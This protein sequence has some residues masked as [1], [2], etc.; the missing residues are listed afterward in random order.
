MAVTVSSDLSVTVS[1]DQNVEKL[2]DKREALK[3]SLKK[4]ESKAVGVS[5]VMLGFLIISYSVP[6]LS[7]DFTEVLMFGVPW[8]SG[9]IFVIAGAFTLVMEKCNTIEMVFASLVVTVLATVISVIALI[10]YIIDMMNNPETKCKLDSTQTCD[11]RH[12]ATMFNLGIK[13]ILVCLYTV[14]TSISSAF[15]IILYKERER[16]NNYSLV[17]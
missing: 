15:S 2:I 9:L 13:S 10:I 4:G 8:W 6:L 14:A 17:L 5:Q 3:E 7:A 16:F 11:H 12:Y 1:A